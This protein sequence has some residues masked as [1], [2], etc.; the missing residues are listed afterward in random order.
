MAL[1]VYST[2]TGAL[3]SW[4][5]GDNDP[6]ADDAHLA[7]NGLALV[8]GLQA[9]DATHVWD[10][11]TQTVKEVP[12]PVPPNPVATANWIMQFAPAECA[13]IRASSD[14]AV[15]HFLFALTI[16]PT[17]NLNNSMITNG[18]AYLV[19]LGLLTQARATV[20]QAWMETA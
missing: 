12:A 8:R 14:L 11:T 16:A 10:E 7:A 1:Y 3:V 9:L 13:A 6:V 18:L 5:P 19:S 17:V 2:T 20:L 15:Q 4:C